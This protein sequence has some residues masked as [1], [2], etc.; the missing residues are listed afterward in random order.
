MK[1]SK[2]VKNNPQI[3]KNLLNFEDQWLGKP[4]KN[5]FPHLARHDQLNR[6]E[7]QAPSYGDMPIDVWDG[8]HMYH[9]IHAELTRKKLEQVMASA[10]GRLR[11]AKPLA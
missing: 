10:P 1:Q 11:S 5:V 9:I 4:H 3:V 6:F 8:G 7:T 2:P